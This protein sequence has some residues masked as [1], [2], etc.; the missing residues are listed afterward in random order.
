VLPLAISLSLPTVWINTPTILVAIAPL[1]DWGADAPAGRWVRATGADA[2]TVVHR[3]R[4]RAGRVPPT[5]RREL[6]GAVSGV[7][8][9]APPRRARP[10]RRPAPGPR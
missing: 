8:A 1:I 10:E 3:L 5:L 7:T 2:T 4:R 6:G 9:T